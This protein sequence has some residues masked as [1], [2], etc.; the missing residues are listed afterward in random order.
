MMGP[1]FMNGWNSANI[2]AGGKDSRKSVGV[3]K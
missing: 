2:K 3:W 1:F